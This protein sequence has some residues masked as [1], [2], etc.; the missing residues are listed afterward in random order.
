MKS[1]LKVRL[2]HAVGVVVV[3]VVCLCS[4]VAAPALKTKV[5]FSWDYPTAELTNTTFLVW[6]STD[7]AIPLTNWTLVASVPGSNSVTLQTVPG[8][9]FYVCQASNLWGV[10]DFSNVVST[11]P[12]PH[13]DVNFR[14]TGA[15]P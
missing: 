1:P 9:H 14:I 12:A 8:A 15:L 5:V 10:S 11:P 6:H 2:N 13:N 4:M 3:G 7:I